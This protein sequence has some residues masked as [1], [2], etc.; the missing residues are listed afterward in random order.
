MIL[1]LFRKDP[2]KDAADA[3]FDAAVA[4]ARAP[5]F[6][7]DF[8]VADTVEGRFE[9]LSLHV[10]LLLRR[11][12]AEDAGPRRFGQH[13][14]DAYFANLDASLRE[15]GVGDLSVGRKIRNM[16]EAFYGRAAAYERAMTGGEGAETLS[17]ALARNVFGASDPAAGEALAGYARKADAAL[18]AQPGGRL[19]AGL[20]AFPAPQPRPEPE[21]EKE[22]A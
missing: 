4:Q 13:L 16:A 2:L 8:G 7:T 15:M 10:F 20:V 21:I 12:K 14:C 1:S 19:R 22:T 9:V 18:A 11:L 6:Y 3:L 17:A 5:V